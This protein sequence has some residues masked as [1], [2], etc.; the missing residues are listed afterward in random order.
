MFYFAANPGMN[1]WPTSIENGLGSRI[2]L[3]YKPLNDPSSFYSRNIEGAMPCGGYPVRVLCGPVQVV[4]E[5][6]ST[7]TPHPARVVSYTYDTGIV[8]ARGRGFLGFAKVSTTD[9]AT[10]IREDKRYLVGLLQPDFLTRF[11]EAGLLHSSETRLEGTGQLAS[12]T[13]VDYDGRTVL[14]SSPRSI[15]VLPAKTTER[16]FEIAASDTFPYRSKVTESFF[17][18]PA[19]PNTFFG[20]ATRVITKTYA[21]DTNASYFETAS[22]HLHNNDTANWWLGRLYSTE[23]TRTAINGDSTSRRSS[24]EYHPSTGL[25]SAEI[26]EEGTSFELKT[27]YGRDGFGNITSTTASSSAATGRT[28]EQARATM[29]TYLATAPNFGR[30]KTRGCNALNQ[31]SSA[32]YDGAYGNPRTTTDANG[33]FTTLNY[34]VWGRSTGSSFAQHGITQSQTVTRTYCPPLGSVTCSPGSIY[35]V[36]AQDNAGGYTRTQFDILEREVVG[37]V[38]SG[39]GDLLT[40]STKYDGAGRLWQRSAPRVSMVGALKFAEIEYDAIGRV[41]RETDFVGHTSR[42]EY[43]GL[44]TVEYD[45]LEHRTTREVDALGNLVRVRDHLGGTVLYNYDAYDNLKSSTDAGGAVT[46]MLYDVRGR[47]K[48]MTDPNMGSWSYLYNVF[49]ELISQ[50]DAKAQTVLMEYDRLGRMKRRTEAEGTTEWQYDYEPGTT[51]RRWIGGLTQVEQRA[52]GSPGALLYRRSH[53]YAAHGSV[54]ADVIEFGGGSYSYTYTDDALGRP[55]KLKY[56][57]NLQIQYR[58]NAHGA[59]DK[60]HRAGDPTTAYSYWEAQSWD[61]WNKIDVSRYGNG[62]IN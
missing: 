36:V 50:T 10:Q 25:L 44:T 49:G 45:P 58:Y 40:S 35:D 37:Y 20:N 42:S 55:F 13:D 28:D 54:S 11:W 12:K 46:S 7:N 9:S 4:S 51:T 34:D 31:C 30:Y 39:S 47:K 18:E 24:F 59:V 2:D 43:Q 21:G 1:G 22:T 29:D 5:V 41:L 19:G 15:A 27:A 52:P 53:S 62:V 33:L 14:S 56:P 3:T 16:A 61:V 23:V 57:S 48:D 60:V 8:D 38:R 17:E 6:R 26:V 32:T